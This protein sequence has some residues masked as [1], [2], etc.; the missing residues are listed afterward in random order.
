MP[1]RTAA[2]RKSARPDV[3]T[4]TKLE[5]LHY[6]KLV[7]EI[8]DRIELKLEINKKGFDGLTIKQIRALDPKLAERIENINTMLE[9]KELGIT[10]NRLP[11]FYP[12]VIELKPTKQDSF[13]ILQENEG[14]PQSKKIR[15]QKRKIETGNIES[16]SNK[17]K[18]P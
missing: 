8:E 5:M 2:K 4:D 11:K 14:T 3:A 12:P 10:K 1:E 13:Q 7:R 18:K 16:K 17:E 6:M 9:V 15:E